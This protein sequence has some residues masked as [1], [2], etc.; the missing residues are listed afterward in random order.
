MSLYFHQQ[1]DI[2]VVTFHN[3]IASQITHVEPTLAL[4]L[5]LPPDTDM[6]DTQ[7]YDKIEEICKVEGAPTLSEVVLPTIHF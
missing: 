4:S 5:V 3:F 1:S 7:V 2:L 6:T